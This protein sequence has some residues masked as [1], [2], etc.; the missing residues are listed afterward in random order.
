MPS[1][2][3]NPPSAMEGMYSHQYDP[4]DVFSDVDPSSR[5]ISCETQP[6]PVQEIKHAKRPAQ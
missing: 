1:Q 6:Q 3:P 2:Q 4:I 5:K